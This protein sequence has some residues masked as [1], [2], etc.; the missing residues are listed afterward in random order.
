MELGHL[1]ARMQN[2]TLIHFRLKRIFHRLLAQ[3]DFN[4]SCGCWELNYVLFHLSNSPTFSLLQLTARLLSGAR[5]KTW[6]YEKLKFH[7][8]FFES[9]C[10]LGILQIFPIFFSFPSFS[11]FH[12]VVIIALCQSTR[13]LT[14]IS[15]AF[16][17]ITLTITQDSSVCLSTQW[18]HLNKT[19]FAEIFIRRL[20]H[21]CDP[22]S[23]MWLW[24][25]DLWVQRY[26][27]NE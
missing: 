6:K 18:T 25:C 21:C 22:R 27:T 16:Y 20:E 1:H 19:F 10:V 9:Q 17:C 26:E 8:F 3:R 11:S 4:L 7:I 23:A 24:E 5:G 13:V 15:R 14:Q 12:F 2:W